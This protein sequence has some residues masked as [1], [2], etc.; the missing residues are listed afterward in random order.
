MFA[1]S[2]HLLDFCFF[3]QQTHKHLHICTWHDD[4]LHFEYLPAGWQ[5]LLM[6]LTGSFSSTE[7]NA[8]FWPITDIFLQIEKKKTIKKTAVNKPHL[9]KKSINWLFA[10]NRFMYLSWPWHNGRLLNM[11]YICIHFSLLF[12]VI[13]SLYR[14]SSI[15]DKIHLVGLQFNKNESFYKER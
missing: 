11:F 5:L 10:E 14:N 9:L 3:Y 8:T 7:A 2:Q 15:V 4:S 13:V 1:S 6:L 12:Y